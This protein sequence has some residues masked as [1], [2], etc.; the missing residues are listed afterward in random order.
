MNGEKIEGLIYD[1]LNDNYPE[2]PIWLDDD[3]DGSPDVPLEIKMVSAFNTIEYN[4]SNGGWSQLLWNCLGTW[5]P[6]IQIARE[7]YALIGAPEQATALD[8]V[9]ELCERDETECINTM[10]DTDETGDQFTEFTR[11]SYATKGTEWEALF[12]TGIYEKRIAWLEA[13]ES[14]IRKLIG[15]ID[16]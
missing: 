7:G 4:I 1:W 2:G 14:R 12:W 6:L 8:R 9:Q 16:A 11:R 13:N 10:N 5:R 15:R 3:Y